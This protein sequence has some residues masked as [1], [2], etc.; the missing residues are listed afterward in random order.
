MRVP[1]YPFQLLITTQGQIVTIGCD[2]RQ[3]DAQT[4]AA[5]RL[6]ARTAARNALDDCD[7][8]YDRVCLR[9]NGRGAQGCRC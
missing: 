3:T 4:T 2:L 6:S 5:L 9:C 8:L 1:S 7:A